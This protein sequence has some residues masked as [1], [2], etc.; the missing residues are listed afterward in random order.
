MKFR[1]VFSISFLAIALSA[2]TDKTGTA[3][4]PNSGA[5]NKN[6]F[7]LETDKGLAEIK[8][9]NIA[10]ARLSFERSLNLAGNSIKDQALALSNLCS[11][12]NLRHQYKTGLELCKKATENDPT[13]QIAKNNFEYAK[14][15]IE[16]LE[17]EIKTQS[18]KLKKPGAS[19]ADRVEIGLK[20]YQIGEFERANQVWSQVSSDSKFYARAQNNLASSYIELGRLD[21]AD[22]ALKTALSLSPKDPTFLANREW[23]RES[24]SKTQN[25]TSQSK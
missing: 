10:A 5:E 15:Q 4:T 24:R 20:Y 9:G 14:K 16:R 7:I 2:C 11:I 17:S 13:L 3:S 1:R 6:P 22:R 12:Y 19:D 8:A 25:S 18:P 21:D 23:L